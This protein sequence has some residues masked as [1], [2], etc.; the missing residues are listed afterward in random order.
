MSIRYPIPVIKHDVKLACKGQN[1]VRA[2]LTCDEVIISVININARDN[3]P[4]DIIE[5]DFLGDV[6]LRMTLAPK[7]NAVVYIDAGREIPTLMMEIM[8]PS[9]KISEH[10]D[11][12]TY[13]RYDGSRREGLMTYTGGTL[14]FS[15]S[16][17]NV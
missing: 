4:D 9:A 14:T 15:P 8:P 6:P 1:I 17:R 7:T 11:E 2:I 10:V 13:T 5:L 12:I 16:R 3:H